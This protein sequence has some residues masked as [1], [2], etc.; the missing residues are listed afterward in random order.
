[1]RRLPVAA[2]E[3]DP[4]QRLGRDGEALAER[5]LRGRGLEVVER[6]YRSRCGEIDLVALDGEQVVFVEVKARRGRGFGLPAEA[7][8]RHKRRRIGRVALAFLQRRGWLERR[9]RFDVVE[10]FVRGGAGSA[11]VRHIVDAFRL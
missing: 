10:V 5:E 1:V 7:V 4:R 6:R 11:D 8:G 9:C 3:Q 2:K